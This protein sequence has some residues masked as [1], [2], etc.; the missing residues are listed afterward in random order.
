MAIFRLFLGSAEGLV[1]RSHSCPL[2]IDRAAARSHRDWSS[3]HR[4]PLGQMSADPER[5]LT[6]QSFPG[7]EEVASRV[8]SSSRDSA[9]SVESV[10]ARREMVTE[11]SSGWPEVL[12]PAPEK[13][14]GHQLYS[15][16]ERVRRPQLISLEAGCH[17]PYS[18]R[19]SDGCISPVVPKLHLAGTAVRR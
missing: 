9:W 1:G 4:S 6:E 8:E 15:G 19:T 10:P 7:Q 16:K 14:S 11:K 3:D 17:D 12:R 18:I 13:S 2:P 5:P